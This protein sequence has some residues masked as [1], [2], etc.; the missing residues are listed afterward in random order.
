MSKRKT[1]EEYLLEVQNKNPNIE[2]IENYIKSS[3]KII[4]KCKKCGYEW[5]ITPNDV[6][7]GYGCPKCA[8]NIKKTTEQYKQELKDKNIQ[9]ECL[10]EYVNGHT[11]ILHRCLIHN[12]EWK[13]TPDYVLKSKG[14][15]ECG[16]ER[17]IQKQT[18][19]QQE[20][21]DKIRNTDINVL[22][23]YQGV[24][25]PIL[26]K[27]GICGY[28]WNTAPNN[29]LKGRRCPKCAGNIKLTNEDFI[30]RMLQI[31]P[32]IQILTHYINANTKVICRCKICDTQW[33][34]TPAHLLNG[35]GCPCCANKQR[36][37]KTRKLHEQFVKEV[38]EVNPYIEILERYKNNN[39]K[40]KV[41]CVRCGRIWYVKA[42]HLLEGHGCRCNIVSKGEVLI[43]KCL[44]I[45]K[46]KYYKEYKFDDCRYKYKLPFDFYLPDYNICIEY[47][48]EQHYMPVTFGGMSE[49]QAEKNLQQCQLRDNIKTRYC[50]ENNIKLL[51]IPY[52]EFENIEEIL[53]RE[54]YH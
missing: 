28:E 11:K 49:K 27:C 6:L 31:N 12:Y 22:G 43:S 54:L 14:C 15:P 42:G 17:M 52:W 32:N 7:H 29:I 9:V 38:L 5:K 23:V 2:P 47:D 53:N 1:N 50:Q 21:M 35:T 46:I 24:F 10:G 8:G 18:F 16:K 4:H 20:Y 41:K 45:Y 44:D 3:I 25:I 39:T 33:E 40:I 30:R 13:C 26:H 34:T 48:G 36:A 19:T 51:R 37:I